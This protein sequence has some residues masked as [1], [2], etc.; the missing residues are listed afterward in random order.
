MAPLLRLVGGPESDVSV[1]GLGRVMGDLYRWRGDADEAVRWL[2]KDTPVSGPAAETYL[3]ALCLPAYGAALRAAGRDEEAAAALERAIALS[4]TFDLPGVRADALHQL[5]LLALGSPWEE[6]A[7]PELAAD[8]LQ[9]A[10][11]LRLELGLRLSVLDSLDALSVLAS[12]SGRTV[13]AARLV[14]AAD[15]G[16]EELGCPRFPADR[17]M[18]DALTARLADVPAE[19]AVLTP[20]EAAAYIRRT[21]GTRG[22]P[23]TGWASLTPTELDVVRLAV[24]GLNN[25]EIGARLYISRSTVKTHLAHVYAKLGVANRTELA[26]VAGRRLTSG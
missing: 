18:Y 16:R 22:R 26:T 12:A 23:A 3:A 6:P 1:P 15:R 25:P 4:R 10:L 9:E 20:E 21:R 14:A 2:A 24:E 7:D 11:G 5:G 17:V 13:E 19:A 8:L